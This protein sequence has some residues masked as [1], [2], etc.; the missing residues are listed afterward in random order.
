[1]P[2]SS[3]RTRCTVPNA[4]RWASARSRASSVA[5]ADASAR[6]AYA[7]SSNV[8][9]TT[10]NAA[11]RAGAITGRRAGTRRTSSAGAPPAG[12]P[13]GR[14][15]RPR[16]A[17]RQTVTRR[18]CSVVH[19]P[20]CG[21][22]ARTRRQASSGSSRSSSRSAGV[23]FSAYVAPSSACG[24]NTGSASTSTSWPRRHLGRARVH[25]AGVEVAD[26]ERLLRRDRARVELL[27]RPV[28][29]HARLGVAGEDRPLDRRGAAPAR[30]QRRVHVHPERLFEQTRRDVETV[31]AHDDPVD[32]LEELRPLR[33][34][35]RD[36]EPLRR[37]LGRRRARRAATA[38][39]R[40]GAREQVRDRRASRRAARGRRRRAVRCAA[41]ASFTAGRRAAAGRGAPPCGARRP[42]GR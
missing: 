27:D 9:R 20:M 14:T 24:V 41:K 28:D 34:V 2:K 21:D 4:N 42:C 16:A 19:A 8:L 37:H 17:P 40:V 18:P 12:R 35:H 29:R 3:T 33:L 38:A 36:A 26:R 25:R 22:S 1:M 15:H 23:I 30:Q 7:S 39:R 5:T 31:G 10:S 6:S 32:G 13:P 11:R